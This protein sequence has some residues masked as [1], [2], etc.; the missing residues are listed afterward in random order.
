MLVAVG[1]WGLYAVAGRFAMKYV[2]ADGRNGAHCT[3]DWHFDCNR[4]CFTFCRTEAT[5]ARVKEGYSGATYVSW[6]R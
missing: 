3:N 4:R 6:P 5:E 2:S 1:I